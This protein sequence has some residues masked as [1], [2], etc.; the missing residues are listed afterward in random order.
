MSQAQ[1]PSV[2]VSSYP[3]IA[4]PSDVNLADS[5]SHQKTSIYV[6]LII[7]PNADS[8]E[9]DQFKRDAQC[10]GLNPIVIG[11]G[12]RNIN[13]NDVSDLKY[14]VKKIHAEH[15]SEKKSTAKLHVFVNMHGNS[16][17]NNHGIK[18]HASSNS[19]DSI[20][21]FKV[22]MSIDCIAGINLLSCKAKIL[23]HKLQISCV[24]NQ[25][26]CMLYSSTKSTLAAVGCD[27][28]SE[29]IR[30]LGRY[31]Q[32]GNNPSPLELFGHAVGVHGDCI[33]LLDTALTKPLTA[34]APKTIEQAELNWQEQWK[35][36]E[37]LESFK[38]KVQIKGKEKDIESL[39]NT[40]AMSTEK[41]EKLSA[42]PNTKL[43]NTLFTR[44]HRGKL[45]PVKE[46]LDRYP[47]LA[48]IENLLGW[49]LLQSASKN[50]DFEL[51]KYLVELDPTTI[52]QQPKNNCVTSLSYACKNGHLKVAQYL[53]ENGAK[54][55]PA[56]D[57][58]PL[59]LY[60]A[61]E[62]GYEKLLVEC[63]SIEGSTVDQP[64]AKGWTP[65]QIACW[66][67]QIEIVK[68]L[69]Q[70]GASINQA[71]EQ[72]LTPLHI[73]CAKGNV[74][75]ALLLLKA[76]ANLNAVDKYDKTP[77]HWAILNGHAE[78]VEYLIKSRM[79]LD[80]Q[81]K[82]G[83]TVLHIA[84]SGGLKNLVEQLIEA[85]ANLNIVD[86]DQDTPLHTATLA[87]QTT[88]MNLLISA[89]AN[90][91]VVNKKGKTAL[92]IAKEFRSEEGK[93][94]LH[95]ACRKGSISMARYLVKLGIDINSQDD[96]GWTPLHDVCDAGLRM[97]EVLHELG[98]N[99]NAKNALGQTP[100]HLATHKEN[101]RIVFDLVK[102][103]I[104]VNAQDETGWTILH[105]ACR[106][107]HKE[108][109]KKLIHSGA[110]L[111]IVDCDN[112]TPLH[113]ACLADQSQV[114]ARLIKAGADISVANKEGKTA[115][116]LAKEMENDEIVN[117]FENQ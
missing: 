70:V 85:G 115:L 90:V 88:V 50:G 12:E 58:E 19:S 83:K 77:A 100:A 33:T 53:Q 38:E 46:I 35:R 3:T 21:L 74:S 23:M 62:N 14:I 22:L 9:I 27:T 91:G 54:I 71:N 101:F 95:L 103:G 108:I 24:L 94:L 67:E 117:Y 16:S 93:T 55:D 81:D 51:V 18:M 92:D 65:L 69:I 111:N 98:A 47:D 30:C 114:V 61:C 8:D 75:L 36:K 7:G 28:F 17:G 76:K 52:N 6:A 34:H 29:V 84:C 49:T 73:A 78:I 113:A 99:L 32:E 37:T 10:A 43:I 105:I 40:K 25:A 57:D 45:A 5:K 116:D 31:N 42:Q 87:G 2:R 4:T 41:V 56:D 20:D 59:L 1:F 72:G 82:Y 39:M 104:N 110:N 68:H 63:L 66:Y 89:G 112:E 11:N 86:E 102:L 96:K 64:N 13:Y 109:I 79:K 60:L 26:Y 107:G 80:I 48:K 97:T 106:E 44:V 15:D